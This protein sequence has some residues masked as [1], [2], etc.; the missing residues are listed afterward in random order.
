M[1][2]ILTNMAVNYLWLKPHGLAESTT[3]KVV[4]IIIVLLGEWF[5]GSVRVYPL[6]ISGVQR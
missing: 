1:M 5:L 2:I 4:A 3:P 6:T